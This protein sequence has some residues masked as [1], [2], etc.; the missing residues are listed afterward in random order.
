MGWLRN[1]AGK[2]LGGRSARTGY[3]HIHR[4]AN[5]AKSLVRD[6]CPDCKQDTIFVGFHTPWYGWIET[7]IRCGR[8]FDGDEGWLPLEFSRTVRID[9][10]H[11]ALKHWDRSEGELITR[12]KVEA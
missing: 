4:P 6:K 5:D 3:V 2:L 10:I 9:N 8:K 11:A 7:C 12:R 1:L